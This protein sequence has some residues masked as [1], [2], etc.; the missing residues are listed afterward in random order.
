MVPSFPFFFVETLVTGVFIIR[1]NVGLYP[2]SY[3]P[4]SP[5]PL[6]VVRYLPSDSRAPLDPS[7][8]FTPLS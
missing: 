6:F 7:V 8:P 4:P 1:A 2:S 3:S 5:L